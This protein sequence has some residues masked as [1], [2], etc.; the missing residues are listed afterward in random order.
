MQ[1]NNLKNHCFQ[2]IRISRSFAPQIHSE[3]ARGT[4]SWCMKAVRPFRRMQT[5]EELPSPGCH[6]LPGNIRHLPN[7]ERAYVVLVTRN[8]PAPGGQCLVHDL[9]HLADRERSAY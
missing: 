7:P 5:P 8:R 9:A 1:F 3:N 4:P 6:L 2:N